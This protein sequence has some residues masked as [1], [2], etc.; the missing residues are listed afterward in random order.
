MAR[1]SISLPDEVLSDA[2]RMAREEGRSRSRLIAEAIELYVWTR[3]AQEMAEGYLEMADMNRA[4]A[5]EALEAAL[6]IWA[7]WHPADR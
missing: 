4:L 7:E 1:I 2:D 6:E 3:E 5:E